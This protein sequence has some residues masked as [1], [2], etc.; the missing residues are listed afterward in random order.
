[1]DKKRAAM[2]LSNAHEAYRK[3]AHN[4]AAALASGV[5]VSE[6][7]PYDVC[8]VRGKEIVCSGPPTRGNMIWACESGSDCPMWYAPGTGNDPGISQ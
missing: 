7:L 5:P 2:K 1:M 3:G 8:P 6:Y 4:L